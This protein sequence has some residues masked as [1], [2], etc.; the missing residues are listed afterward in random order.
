MTSASSI[1]PAHAVFLRACSA[2]GPDDWDGHETVLRAMDTGG[3]ADRLHARGA[4]R[5]PGTGLARAST[6][7]ISGAPRGRLFLDRLAAARQAQLMQL[8][9]YR[10]AARQLADALS[11]H[12]IQFVVYKGPVLGEEIYGDLSLRAFRDC[13][14]LVRPGELEA[15]RTVLQDLGY[16]LPAGRQIEQLVRSGKHAVGMKRSDGAAVDLHWWIASDELF[17]EDPEIIWRSCR[18]TTI[19]AISPDGGCRPSLRSSSWRP[20]FARTSFT[21]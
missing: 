17:T 1:V 18:P 11:A 2:L 4:S 20:I 8:M 12:D 7:G 16:A 19:R 14:I 3:V 10:K 15:A 6:G 9:V 21:K 13:D 5:A